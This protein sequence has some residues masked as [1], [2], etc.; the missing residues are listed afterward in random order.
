MTTEKSWEDLGIDEKLSELGF[1]PNIM[2][3]SRQADLDS[4][5]HAALDQLLDAGGLLV[6]VE[7]M[8]EPIA[9]GVIG[10]DI[11]GEMQETCKKIY[12]LLT[13]E[14]EDEQPGV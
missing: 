11:P 8:V 3:P 6:E 10:A 7:A 2:A 5:I 1:A 9:N 13:E 12:E 14:E 4:R